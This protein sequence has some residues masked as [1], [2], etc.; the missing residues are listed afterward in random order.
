MRARVR[1]PWRL[2]CLCS[3]TNNAP[4][5]LEV[6]GDG[7]EADLYSGLGKPTPAHTPETI[8]ALPG[9]EDLF[10]P[11]S[12]PMDGSVPGFKALLDFDLIASPHPG[13]H[14]A[15]PATLG[16]HSLTKALTSISAVGKDLSWIIR[17]S[18]GACFAIVHIGR[19][20]GDFFHQGRAGIGSHMSLEAMNGGLSLM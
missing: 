11:A 12:D 18:I 10:D 15:C 14:D 13:C 5:A 16:A 7:G 8:A 6:I 2:F 1:A 3:L 9:S 19:C 20:D 17:Q 4:C